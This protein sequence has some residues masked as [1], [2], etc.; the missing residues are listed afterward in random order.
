[1]AKNAVGAYTFL[2]LYVWLSSKNSSSLVLFSPYDRYHFSLN[3]KELEEESRVLKNQENGLT[4]ISN[5]VPNIFLSVAM[6][7]VWS[8]T[9]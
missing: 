4:F 9:F 7:C 1:M 2:T 5:S 6:Y 3:K 8:F